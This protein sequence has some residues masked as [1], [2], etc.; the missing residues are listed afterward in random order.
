MKRLALISLLLVG[1]CAPQ[2]AQAPVPNSAAVALAPRAFPSLQA[3]ADKVVSEGRV[4]SITIAVG[5][6]DE[7]TTYISA[8]NVTLKSSQPSSSDTL[9][10]IYSM[11]K[12]VT[13][14]AAMILVDRGSSGWTS[15]S[16]I[17]F[18][19][20]RTVA[21]WWTPHGS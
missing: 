19:H 6:G 11:T 7:P 8:G 1:A 20:L 3:F 15:R 18:P 10:R 14:I 13:G 17:S 2:L 16:R 5:V 21:C 12:P 4:P 9:W